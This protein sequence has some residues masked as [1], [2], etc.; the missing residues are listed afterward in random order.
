V[1]STIQKDTTCSG[2]KLWLSLYFTQRTQTATKIL[3]T[4]K[5]D[6]TVSYVGH[7]FRSW[8]VM[9]SNKCVQ[10]LTKYLHDSFCLMRQN[11]RYLSNIHLKS[12]G[13]SVLNYEVATIETLVFC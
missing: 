8:H 11:R 5:L 9:T 2:L 13:S 12:I 10:L 4:F 1:T 7:T 6:I 3:P